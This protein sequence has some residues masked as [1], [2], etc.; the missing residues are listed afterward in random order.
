LNHAAGRHDNR[1]I[2]IGKSWLDNELAHLY[3]I[4]VGRLNEAAKRN[5]DRF[6]MDFMFQLTD[7]EWEII[8]QTYISN[9]KSQFAIARSGW[10]GRR[11]APFV[12]TEQGVAMLSSVLHTKRAILVNIAIIRTFV[13]IREFLSTHKELA[14]K[15][16]ALEHKVGKH[17]EEIQLIFN[18][19]RK[20]ME[21]PPVEE[22]PKR[23]IG[24]HVN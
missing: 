19:I 15:L 23:K 6:P 22:K 2:F 13:K 18:A 1:L 10:G 5:L 21:P 3:D 20:L 9:L 12:F 14:Q 16:T 17:D 4:S 8:K 24:F 11:N 7:K